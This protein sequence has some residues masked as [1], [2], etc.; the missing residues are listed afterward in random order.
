ML[1][2]TTD[3]QSSGFYGCSWTVPCTEE[4][5]TSRVFIDVLARSRLK[6]D[7]DPKALAR[8]VSVAC[9]DEW[10]LDRV[11]HL[12][13]ISRSNT[14]ILSYGRRSRPRQFR[15]ERNGYSEE[16]V[17]LLLGAAI[18]TGVYTVMDNHFFKFMD[19]V[20]RQKDGG[21][22]GMDLTVE[23]A[24]I[25]MSIWDEKFRL[26]LL[27]LGLDLDLY[28][29]YVDDSL[30]I[31]GAIDIGWEYCRTKKKLVYKEEAE[32]DSLP[33]DQR[34]FNIMR[35]I[36]N[37]IDDSIQMEVDV[38]SLHNNGRLTGSGGMDEG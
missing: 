26:R 37:E 31:G 19:C 29:R 25:Y 16:E 23:L 3:D 33:P 18:A 6:F 11:R 4:R 14:T 9:V 20:Y 15:N 10:V 21:S 27:K 1:R 8:Y 2:E 5:E 30:Q 24:S 17:R 7:V 38:P 22:I 28:K 35:D 36:A 34:T 12:L 32:Y 13:P